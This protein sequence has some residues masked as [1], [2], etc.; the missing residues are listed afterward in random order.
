MAASILLHTKF[1]PP[2]HGPERLSRPHLIERLQ[3]SLD[4]RLILLS[5]PPGY[6]KTT[7]L[8]ELATATDLPCAWYQLD[9]TDGDPIVF[10]ACLL[11]SLRRAQPAL[12]ADQVVGSA[13]QALLDSADTAVSASPERILTVLIN[14]LTESVATPWLLILEDYHL[15]TNPAV[16]HLV[17]T[18]IENG[19]PDQHLLISTRS[20]PPLALP[21]LRA[22]GLLAELRPADLRF[23]EQEVK[24]WVRRSL[25]DISPESA[26]LLG[27]KTEGWAA[28]VQIALSTLAGKD[29]QSTDRFIT[30]LS[31][32]HHFIFDY[33]AAEVFRQQPTT[34]QQF[35]LKT[36]VLNQMN[37]AA[38]NALPG[39][40]EAQSMLTHLEQ[41][42]LF[43]ISLDEQQQWYRYHHLFR[44]FLLARLRREQ[45]EQA[46]K[47]E[48]AAGAY[49]EAQRE[50]EA[51]LGHYQRAGDET[52]AAR[53]LAAFAPDYVERGRVELL[54]RY[55]AGLSESALR[56]R[57]EL[58]L[59]AGDTLRR[60]GQVGAATIRY[61]EARAAFAARNDQSGVCR[62]LTEL[63]EVARAQ[64][65]Y[66]RAQM[67]A[68]EALAHGPESD[69]A[70]RAR[71]LMALAK[72]EGFLTGMDR[73]HELAEAAVAEARQAGTAISPR[74]HA[75]LLRSLGQICWW[76]GDPQAT[77][78]Y[79]REALQWASDDLSPLAA[80]AFITM[81]TP[82]LYWCDLDEALRCA[83]RGLEMAQQLQLNEL[84]PA[85]Y[86]TLGNVLTRRGEMARAESSLR[87]AM[88]SAQQLGLGSYARVMAAGFLAYNL[89]G[90][91]RLDEA[92]QLA[93]TALWS[94]GGSPDTYEM[95]VCRSV[96]ADVALSE[97]RVA[98]AEQL[99]TSLLEVDRRRQFR[100][101]LA[102]I[103]FG[104]AYICLQ[105]G[106]HSEG[107]QHAGN[108][109]DIIEPTGAV[110]L[111]LD[112]GE[113]ARVVC[114]A[115]VAAGQ[116]T[117]FVERVLAQLPGEAGEINV[118]PVAQTAVRVQTLGSFR[119]WLGEE[120]VTQE[121]WVSTKARDL[122]AYFV[123][124]RRERIPVDV[125]F[126]ALW[127]E[128]SSGSKTAFHTALYRMRQALRQ[129]EQ[130][131]KFALVE[132][133]SYWLDTTRFQ[134]DV[135]EFDAL[136][137][138]ARSA[139]DETAGQRY[140]QAIALY[141]GPYLENMPYYDWAM[142]ERRRLDEAYLAAL[143]ALADYYA[144]NGRYR[145]ALDLTRRALQSDPL[146]EEIHCA[147]LRHYAALGDRSGLVRHYQQLQQTLRTELNLPPLPATQTLY[148]NLLES[149]K[150]CTK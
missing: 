38:C 73:G 89:V 54:Q 138:Q 99:F 147:A 84:L 131:A 108:A 149:L 148:E 32:S 96:L 1:L 58:L 11:E 83:E 9:A 30:E 72:S 145:E 139:H 34:T 10:L 28:A 129:P 18:L 142:P 3:T 31:G 123:T 125:A 45:P 92:R 115:L 107:I 52:A 116:A 87:Q 35:L 132:A 120:E 98:E 47:L 48:Q 16:H 104:L 81:A 61:E 95:C 12:A 29:K 56:A 26:R 121:R 15:I 101:P 5:A 82:Y 130:T 63:A 67:L 39:M 64:G 106:R 78:R 55:L 128:T 103:Y 79:C 41:H 71:A 43:V 143:S 17:E 40:T 4:K 23:G 122:L 127:P 90:Q 97:G 133:G 46:Q 119:V 80:Q 59:Y 85:A 44:E 36:A 124:F 112:Q 137:T 7:L 102:M 60:L 76:H 66:R 110:Q 33:L 140:E 111:F 100:I 136:L 2:R 134:I 53:V 13:A 24:N 49:Y 14:E 27:E 117:P 70:G 25:P 141:Q 57:P 118:M 8:A 135:D 93:E 69:H 109:L 20:D 144:G 88:A 37:A 94:Y 68:T 77:V 50:L 65:D 75:A 86:A 146:R 22:R 74:G 6:G 51:A 62:V 105:N 126:E 113:R 19:P 21:R 150:T 42:N 91:G 114:Q